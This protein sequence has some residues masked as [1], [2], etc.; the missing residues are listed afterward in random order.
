MD[1]QCLFGQKIF[2]IIFGIKFSI[3]WRI[4]SKMKPQQPIDSLKDLEKL[5]GNK[6]TNDEYYEGTYFLNDGIKHVLDR[7]P[8]ISI[9][10]QFGNG[11]KMALSSANI[12][13]GVCDCCSCSCASW[14]ENTILLKV[15]DLEKN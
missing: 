1:C 10:V 9:L 4:L 3:G 7:N 15:V 2:M 13:L 14:D 5:I 11:A 6:I 8:T 12:L